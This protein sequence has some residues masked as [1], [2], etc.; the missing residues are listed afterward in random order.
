MSIVISKLIEGK[1]NSNYSNG[2]LSDAISL[3]VKLL[4]LSN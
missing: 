2:Y 1:N 4:K 3:I